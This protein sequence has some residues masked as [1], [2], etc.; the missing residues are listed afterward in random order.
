ML[1]DDVVISKT[2]IAGIVFLGNE[3]QELHVVEVAVRDIARNAAGIRRQ[4]VSF[5]EDFE[6]FSQYGEC[7][8]H[9]RHIEIDMQVA[10]KIV[11]HAH[12]LH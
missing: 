11:G 10:D 1:S 4:E 5:E 8:E 6:T 2:H 7:A 12:N 9:R 3:L